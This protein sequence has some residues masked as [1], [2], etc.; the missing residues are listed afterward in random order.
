LSYFVIFY[1]FEL[2][3]QLFL[4]DI[5]RVENKMAGA[6]CLTLLLFILI[7]KLVLL[8][9]KLKGF[10]Y[11]FDFLIS[12]SCQFSCPWYLRSWK[13]DGGCHVPDI[14]PVYFNLKTSLTA[15]KAKGFVIIFLIFYFFELSFQLSLY[16]IWGVENKMAGAT[17]LTLLLFILILKLVLLRQN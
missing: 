4:C 3:V 6:T 10:C 5:R 12:L 14:T 13:Q 17:C 15:T 9:H 2:S 16:H 11:F 8:R 1:F 7:L